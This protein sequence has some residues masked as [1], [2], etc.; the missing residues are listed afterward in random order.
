MDQ[1]C[2]AVLQSL[3][4]TGYDT[5]EHVITHDI[6]NCHRTTQERNSKRK[7]LKGSTG[8]PEKIH[9]HTEMHNSTEFCSLQRNNLDYITSAQTK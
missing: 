5:S 6:H 1:D 9:V 4:Y 3:Y 2:L 8:M 7:W